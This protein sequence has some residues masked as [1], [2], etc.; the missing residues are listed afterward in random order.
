[1][2]QLGSFLGMWHLTITRHPPST[3]HFW[4]YRLLGSMLITIHKT[5]NAEF[6]DAWHSNLWLYLAIEAQ[7]GMRNAQRSEGYQD[8][9]FRSMVWRPGSLLCRD[10]LVLVESLGLK[11]HTLGSIRDGVS[12]VVS[13]C[14]VHE[15]YCVFLVPAG[16]VAAPSDNAEPS[17]QDDRRTGKRCNSG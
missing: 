7:K 4:V 15:H 13:S 14:T 12:S 5:V 10:M 1:M 2:W 11:D 9:I 17:A 16:L 3:F 8:K 6:L